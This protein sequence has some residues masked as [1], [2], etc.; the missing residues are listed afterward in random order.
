[1]G[2]AECVAEFVCEGV[3]EVD[4]LRAVGGDDA[5][6]VILR[7]DFDVGVEDFAC[8]FV[9]RDGGEGHDSA[10]F[11]PIVVAKDDD[12]GVALRVA[13]ESYSVFVG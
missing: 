2:D 8:V 5:I 11:A 4:D 3:L 9:L 12:V 6:G 10:R 7:V 13:V 1:M